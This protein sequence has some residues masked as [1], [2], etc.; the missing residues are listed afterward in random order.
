MKIPTRFAALTIA[1]SALVAFPAMADEWARFTWS[2]RDGSGD[3]LYRRDVPV[4]DPVNGGV[5]LRDS[6]YSFHVVGWF[7]L[8]EGHW[9]DGNGGSVVTHTTETLCEG[10]FGDLCTNHFVTFKLGALSNGDPKPW[11]VNVSLPSYAYFEPDGRLPLFPPSP[12]AWGGFGGTISN[13]V[14]NER[15]GTINTFS[16]VTHQ[17][18]AAPVPEPALPLLMGLGLAGVA[19]GAAKRRRA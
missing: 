12:D 14:N 10:G 1:A 3:I 6:I 2:G 4:T 17:R 5:T 8:N 11:Q 16:T 9:F 13:T 7:E 15:Y 19:L 18:V